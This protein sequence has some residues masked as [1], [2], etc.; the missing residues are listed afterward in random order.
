MPTMR[1]TRSPTRSTSRPPPIPDSSRI[2][3]NADTTA[4]AAVGPTP[5]CRANNGTAG[6]TMPTP[7]APQNA[8]NASVN[9]LRGSP[10]N[11]PGILTAASS[12]SGH[13]QLSTGPTA[14]VGP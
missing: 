7:S 11:L 3:A 10:G 8:T 13:P 1:A 5:N 6:T 9:V 14:D 4:P 12:P 2:S